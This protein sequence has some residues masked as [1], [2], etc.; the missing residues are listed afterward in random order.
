MPGIAGVISRSPRPEYERQLG[1]MIECKMHEDFYALG[2]S[3]HKDVGLYVGWAEGKGSFSDCNPIWNERKDVCLVFSGEVYDDRST[4][5]WLRSRGHEF[6]AAN[7]GYLVHLYEELGGDFFRTLNGRF[8]GVLVDDRFGDVILFNDR[9][10]LKRIYIHECGEAFYFSSEAKSLLAVKPELRSLDCTGLGELFCIGSVLEDRTLFR[11]ISLLPCGSRWTFRGGD[12]PRKEVYFR[13]VE[14]ERSPILGP[15]PFYREF[16]DTFVRILPRYFDAAEAIGMSLTGGVDT[17]MIMACADP[18]FGQLPCYTF[19]SMYRESADVRVARVV[20]QA[21]RQP[22]RIIRLDGNFL[23]RFPEL[24]EKAVYISDGSMDVSGS[25]ELYVNRLARGIAPVRMTGNY[26]QEVMNHGRAFKPEPTWRNLFEPEFLSYVRAAE[27]R[28]EAFTGEHP[29]SFN[30]TGQTSWHHQGRFVL[31]ESQ[32]TVRSPFLDNDLVRL[33]Y[34]APPE[35][36]GS[37][38]VSHRLIREGN[39]SLGAIG[40]DRGGGRNANGLLRTG[41]RLFQEATFKAEY[42]YD[43]GMPHWMA[44]VDSLLKPLRLESLFLGRHK[45]YHFRTWY[46]NELSTFVRDILL[47]GRAKSRPHF[48][49]RHLQEMVEGHVRGTRNFTTEIHKALTVELICR[50]LLDW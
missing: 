8:H 7:A 39:P 23:A 30:L 16:R 47:D 20:A 18:E 32:L 44:W 2:T 38:E 1:R 10:G 12:V 43:Y 49:G 26:G 40:M 9:Y 50:R 13:T 37:R 15:E 5:D 14:L 24:A 17:R 27:S 4:R 48:S 29:L 25:S 35:A 34:M 6:D 21:C 33:V 42:A 36:V 41:A 19:C 46:A 45:F 11:G 3:I 28:Y 31:E 22:H